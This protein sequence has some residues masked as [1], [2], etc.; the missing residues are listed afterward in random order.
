MF[1]K[2]GSSVCVT[3]AHLWGFVCVCVCVCVCV[4]RFIWFKYEDT[5]VYNDMGTTM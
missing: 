4:Y 5:N 2:S 1:P 3:P